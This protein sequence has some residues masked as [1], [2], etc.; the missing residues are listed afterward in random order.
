MKL[1]LLSFAAQVL[2][3]SIMVD[4]TTTYHHA[5]LRGGNDDDIEEDKTHQSMH[6]LLDTKQYVEMCLIYKDS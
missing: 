1:A 5:L 4:A 6:I 3:A 2:V